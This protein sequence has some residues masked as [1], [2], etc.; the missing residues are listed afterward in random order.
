MQTSNE[1]PTNIPDLTST[2]FAPDPIIL[3]I[4]KLSFLLV[5]VMYVVYSIVLTRQVRIMNSTVATTLG[6]VIQLIA[7]INLAFSLV[8]TL[9]VILFL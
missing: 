5:A 3:L 6:P 9:G 7:W 8:I 1:L 4:V 2:F